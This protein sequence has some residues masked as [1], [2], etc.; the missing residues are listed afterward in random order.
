MNQMCNVVFIVLVFPFLEGTK[1]Y[2][3]G[4]KILIHYSLFKFIFDSVS[5]FLFERGAADN[6]RIWLPGNTK[7]KDWIEKGDMEEF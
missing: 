4:N 6:L 5:N 7:V 3:I 2:E 1:Q